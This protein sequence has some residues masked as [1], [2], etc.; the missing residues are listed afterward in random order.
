MNGR[1]LPAR[2]R[3]V[4]ELDFAKLTALIRYAY[5]YLLVR[6]KLGYRTC[7][8]ITHT[9]FDGAISAALVLQRYPHARLYFTSPRNLYKVIYIAGKNAPS[10]IPHLLYILDLSS[11]ELYQSRLI[12]A[13][14]EIRRHTLVE[15][16]WIDHHYTQ[17]LDR[18]KHYVDLI[19]DPTA[20]YTAQV[21]ATQLALSQKSAP[22]LVLLQTPPS[23]FATYWCTV[24][25]ATLKSPRYELRVKVLRALARGVT[26][27]YVDELYR[28][29]LDC[30]T[31]NSSRSSNANGN[32]TQVYETAQGYH[33]SLMQFDG[34][35]E[36]YP[37]VY[38]M[39]AHN[40]L[41]FLLV[42]FPNGTFSAYKAKNSSI[43]LTPL[44]HLVGGKGHAYAFHFEPQL[45]LSDE[46][47]RPLT[48]RAL[49]EKVQEVL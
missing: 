38:E 18:L 29:G 22:L 36:L 44:L 39:I 8:I 21:V 42:E 24:L 27:P 30:L 13:I 14:R 41:D 34:T 32:P 5:L 31:A 40:A 9:D 10:T 17:A 26:P 7:S 6:F 47:F 43:D 11:S 23:R 28:R 33:F 37:A 2:Y 35:S 12:K 1:S 16:K 19:L 45:R 25:R 15:I 49:I 20:N 4:Q 48:V 3:S 46:L